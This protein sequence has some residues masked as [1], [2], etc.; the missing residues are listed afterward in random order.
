[1]PRSSTA[2]NVALLAEAE[3]ATAVREQLEEMITRF[4]EDDELLATLLRFHISQGDIDAAEAFL[5]ERIDAEQDA[6]RAAAL[7]AALHTLVAVV[8]PAQQ[9]PLELERAQFEF[10]GAHRG[11]GQGLEGAGWGPL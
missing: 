2:C 1:M 7:R 9:G 11:A 3:D 4:P 6:E 10:C 8:E 5:R